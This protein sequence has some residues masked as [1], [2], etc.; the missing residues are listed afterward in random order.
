MVNHNI[1][2]HGI[3]L[4]C[5][6]QKSASQAISDLELVVWEPFPVNQQAKGGGYLATKS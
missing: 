6:P 4:V 3:V 1:M 2:L 5:P